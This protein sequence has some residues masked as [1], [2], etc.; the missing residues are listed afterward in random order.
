MRV[1]VPESWQGIKGYE[2]DLEFKDNLPARLKPKARPI[3][4]AMMDSVNAEIKRL[5]KYFW[6]PST[7]AITSP[8]VVAPKATAPL[9][10]ICGD[11][12]V[13]NKYIVVFNYPIPDV[14][15]EKNIMLFRYFMSSEFSE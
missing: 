11:F 10:R 12:R 14:I 3:P 13:V 4:P 1:F 7:S 15:H 5:L 8:L 9:I 6:E 2:L